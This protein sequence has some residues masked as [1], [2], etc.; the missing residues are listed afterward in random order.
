[1][2]GAEPE[3]WRRIRRVVAEYHDLL[4]P[5]CREAVL[6]VLRDN[7][8]SNIAVLPFSH[9]DRLGVIRASR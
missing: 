4:R 1:M 7:G 3:V 5:G 8:F 6:E 9:D 2:Q